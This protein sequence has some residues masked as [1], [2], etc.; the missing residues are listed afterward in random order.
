[1]VPG[2]IA[3]CPCTECAAGRGASWPPP[4]ARVAAPGVLV[5]LRRPELLPPVEVGELMPP[6]PFTMSGVVVGVARLQ[7]APTALVMALVVE[8]ADGKLRAVYW[9][10]E[11][12]MVAPEVM[13]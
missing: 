3:S 6:P 7:L 1:M 8:A 11:L 13:G 5:E 4:E 9:H 2:H 10:R 12:G